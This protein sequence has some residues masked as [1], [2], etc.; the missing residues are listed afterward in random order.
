MAN[1]VLHTVFI[2]V[3]I[4]LSAITLT[5]KSTKGQKLEHYQNV[6]PEIR[7]AHYGTNEGLSQGKIKGVSIDR[8][9]YLWIGTKDGLNRYDGH[10]FITYR[11]DPKKSTT[12]SDN[13]I[14]R[15]YADSKNR[16]WITS[17]YGKIDMLDLSTGI[18]S[19]IHKGFDV[20]NRETEFYTYALK[21][22]FFGNIYIAGKHGKCFIV[23]NEKG[24]QL[25]SA[26]NTYPFLKDYINDNNRAIH[27]QYFLFPN[28]STI[29]LKKSDSLYILT[30]NDIATDKKPSIF[31]IKGY[32][33]FGYNRGSKHDGSST[34]LRYKNGVIES[35]N[36]NKKVFDFTI[37]LRDN[38]EIGKSVIDTSHNLW[39]LSAD[40]QFIIRVGLHTKAIDTFSLNWQGVNMNARYD[41]DYLFIDHNNNIWI[42][43]AGYGLFKLNTK[44]IL[45][46]PYPSIIPGTKKKIKQYPIR[47]DLAGKPKSYNHQAAQEWGGYIDYLSN[48]NQ[49]KGEQYIQR[50]VYDKNGYF[51]LSEN[52]KSSKT[53]YLVKIKPDSSK[54]WIEEISTP[55][56]GH[57]Y[58][59][60]EDNIWISG[61]NEYNHPAL[62]QYDKRDK[63]ITEYTFPDF[64]PYSTYNTVSDWYQENGGTIWLATTSG[65]YALEP[66][67]KTWTYYK[68][69]NNDTSLSSNVVLSIYPD[70][71]KPDS[72]L[73]FGTEG[74]GLNKLNKKIGSFTCYNTQTGLPNNVIY[75]IL[76]DK[77]DNLWLAT[78]NGLCL[79][80]PKTEKPLR[81]FTYKNGLP[82]N[83]FNRYFYSKDKKNNLYLSTTGGYITFNPDDFYKNLTPSNI[84]INKLKVLGEPVSYEK[85]TESY[86]LSSPIENCN[87]L[88][89]DH[90]QN[91]FT[92]GY[93]LLDFS[94]PE[95]NRYKY[96]LEGFNENWVDAG[97]AT[98]A[99]YTNL[100][101]GNY[102]FK[103][104]GCNSNGVWNA[105]PATID[106]I[107]LEPWWS[108][109][110][111]RLLVFI[112]IASI[113]YLMYKYRIKQ[114]MK[115]EGMRNSIARDLHD[116]IGSTL[117]S[118]SL[119][120]TVIK[121][122]SSE[123]SP[124][125]T[126]LIDKITQNTSEMMESMNDIVWATKTTNDSL[127]QLINRMR[128]FAV[129]TAEAKGIRL[130]FK[131]D[132]KV[133]QVKINMQ[134]R[135]NI[136]LLFKEAMNNAIKHSKCSEVKIEIHTTVNSIDVKIKDNG[137][138]FEL[139]E[140]KEYTNESLSGNGI[141]SMKERAE[142][143]GG[144]LIID[145]NIR[146]GTMIHLTVPL[147]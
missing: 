97:N 22:D 31:N 68:A 10:E 108:S 123:L 147:K 92:I 34:I 62:F 139:S 50:L 74:G 136:Y 146:S 66:E 118:I 63:S 8:K 28:D 60:N 84:I 79:F 103:V 29:A 52:T 134:Q 39:Y 61:S 71:V 4:L 129:S 142:V 2:K 100:D 117:S 53:S 69:A 121:R 91:M 101:P 32:F 81:T 25:Q 104:I 87:K 6:Y 102:T 47:Y 137:I 45:F 138:G 17:Q 94:V 20:S 21:E 40:N 14:W 23:Q 88:V 144:V 64:V 96:L 11:H 36:Q 82:S 86:K 128:S 113:L 12:I 30:K 24:F 33:I 99:T 54:N 126:S 55:F 125:L 132:G 130:Q 41:S 143:L 145:S 13:L 73:W 93:A 65:A 38:V 70:P 122:N 107:I 115:I 49:G 95:E 114:I 90:N 120:G 76:S 58:I 26:S 85:P 48:N 140:T 57:V 124:K 112:A 89:F 35:Y 110:W 56:H 46:K 109:W 127:A 27:N 3:F 72:F 133:E 67:L 80:D 51:W 83:E 105:E 131:I 5:C 15:I 77:H 1:C 111:F 9:G 42:T 43:T 135:K 116:E 19:H 75:S 16:L 59:D 37:L 98:N 141:E 119:Y 78:N 44:H 18:V 7:V 106:I